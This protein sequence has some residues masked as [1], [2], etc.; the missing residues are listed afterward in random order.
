M[1]VAI[2]AHHI[3]PVRE[4]G[5]MDGN[6]F[7]SNKDTETLFNY[8][9]GKVY[10]GRSRPNMTTLRPDLILVKLED[11]MRSQVFSVGGTI[12][13]PIS[14]AMKEIDGSKT[15]SNMEWNPKQ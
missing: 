13:L 14:L 4:C 7:F 8:Q 3:P 6:L 5:E 15:G 12:I 9:N 1:K 11:N 2:E 10:T